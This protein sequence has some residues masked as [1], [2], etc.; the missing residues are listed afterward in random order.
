[1]SLLN[2]TLQTIV[3][4]LRD[5]S[6]NVTQQ[7][8]HNRVFDAYEAKALVFEAIT[9]EQQAVMQQYAGAIPPLHPVGQPLLVDSWSDLVQIHRDGNLYQLLPRRAR[10]NPS[11][12]VLRAICS[13]TGSPFQMEHRVDPIDYKFVFRAADFDC[14][15]QFNVQ[16]QDK[17]PASI[18]FDGILKAPTAS[19]LL[20]FHNSL[21]PAHVNNIAGTE[22]FLRQWSNQPADGDR[23]RQIKQLYLDL[24]AKP[25]LMF[26]G[27]NAVPGRELLN[28]AKS[29]NVFIYAKKGLHYLYHA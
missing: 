16:H 27:T 28:Y 29:K 9:A 2:T 13:S 19:G 7:K 6:G 5:M 24:L 3:V 14:R 20:S 10:N 12:N 22:Q 21:T 1:M 17:V 4:R 11:Y 8:L 26:L 23:H 25:T 15:T 18:W